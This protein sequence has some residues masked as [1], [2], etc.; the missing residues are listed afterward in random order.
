[1]DIPPVLKPPI[2]P[3]PHGLSQK[4]L[5]IVGIVLG[6]LYG[7][8]GRLVFGLDVFREYFEVMSCV[9]IFGMPFCIGFI[10]VWFGPYRESQKADKI[11]IPAW[12]ASFSCLAVALALLWEGLIC[13]FVWVP[14]VFV[15]STLGGL[16]AALLLK[17]VTSA[18]DRL[19]CAFAVMLLPFAVAPLE[20][21]HPYS[22]EIKTVP[23]Q[24]KIHASPQIVWQEIRSVPLIQE[25][26]QSGSFSHWL[27]FPRPLEAKLVGEGPG[28][29]RY[30]TFERGVLFVETI[31][32][33]REPRKLSFC[34]HADTEHIPPT[35]FDEHVIIGG[36]YFE[37]LSGCYEIEDIGGGDVI[38]HLS[39][40]QRLSTRFNF[41]SHYW[42][43]Y[44]M[45]DLQNYILRIIKARCEA[46]GVEK[47]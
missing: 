7:L 43:E 22:T 25:R 10:A 37:V 38:L 8:A 46:Q 14:L 28:A 4:R 5:N 35:T 33:W 21:L 40:E 41:Y 13:I 19:R 27:G 2:D 17:V 47:R 34:I 16:F 11:L 23:T 1:M 26:E 42:T 30:A 20:Q 39:S 12:L 32:E 15:L 3:K 36:K 44:L 29:V 31:T 18:R 24:I 9:F 6:A 45:A